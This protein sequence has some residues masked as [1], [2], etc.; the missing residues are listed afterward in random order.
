MLQKAAQ[1]KIALA[2]IAVARES[3]YSFE[4]PSDLDERRRALG[5]GSP[6]VEFAP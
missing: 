4:L 5:V 6:F 2:P 1:R 3:R